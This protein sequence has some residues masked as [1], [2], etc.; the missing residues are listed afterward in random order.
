MDMISTEMLIVLCFWMCFKDSWSLRFDIISHLNISIFIFNS[1]H[2]WDLI[3]VTLRIKVDI[4]GSTI[5]DFMRIC[6]HPCKV[7]DTQ[8]EW[9]GIRF[10][11]MRLA[12]NNLGACILKYPSPISFCM[13]ARIVMFLMSINI[14]M[15]RH[16]SCLLMNAI[17][18][19]DAL[20]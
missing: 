12:W 4:H 7:K 8:F 20:E 15:I 1:K 18:N 5:Y 2:A 14:D 11:Y 19:T 16:S 17:C 10:I 6:I 9:V 13:T 3:T